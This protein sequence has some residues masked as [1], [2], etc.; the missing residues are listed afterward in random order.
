M[1]ISHALEVAKNSLGTYQR[2]LDVTSH[3]IA[4]ANNAKF[5]RQRITFGTEQSTMQNMTEIGAGVKIEDIL[6]VRDNL[7]DIQI[8]SYN[9]KFADTSKR[10]VLF[11]H[12]EGLFSE[13]TELGLS[14]T[15][16]SF[17]NSWDELAVTPNST[18]LRR[19]VIN[20][21]K[22]VAGQINNIYEGL[23]QVKSDVQFEAIEKT[24]KLNSL[25][26]EIQSLNNQVGTAKINN[27]PANDL[28]DKRDELIDE[29]SKLANINVVFDKNSSA[30]ISIG[31]VF[32]VDQYNYTEFKV[33][34][35]NE[36]MVISKKDGSGIVNLNSGELSALTDV[37]TNKVPEYLSFI[38]NIGNAIMNSVNEL[39]ITGY[40]I[41]EPPQSN[42]KFFESFAGGEL[43]INTKILEDPGFIAVSSNGEAG[44]SDLALL[45]AGI[46]NKKIIGDE[47]INDYYVS[48]LS[49]I[50][51]EKQVN[52]EYV[53]SNQLVLNQLEQQKSSYS[54][55]SVDEEMTNI[56]KFQRS[57]EAS[58]K[59]IRVADEM[60]ETLLSMV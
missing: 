8:R 40:T 20:N 12:I 57:Y 55:V 6:R 58:A 48:L 38:E 46:K 24:E 45:I 7:T 42:I 51:T 9:Q 21:A 11:E 29:L 17:F 32:A 56:I 41:T 54:G 1:P 15:L 10:S 50:G 60:L 18:P 4:N 33:S 27:Q 59:L 23:N 37:Y 2:A 36:K 43:K 52:D 26:K 5:S 44:N 25:I 16:T 35:Q 39:H 30:S 49:N 31:G 22:S 34:V 47:S 53:E 14:N 28:L 3:N 19:N 13:P